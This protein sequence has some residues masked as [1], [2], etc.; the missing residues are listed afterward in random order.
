MSAG[1]ASPV[2]DFAHSIVRDYLRELG[3]E[4]TL[5]AFT[6]EAKALKVQPPTTDSWYAVSQR[7]DLPA[8]IRANN[9]PHGRHHLAMLEVLLEHLLTETGRVR[10]ATQPPTLTV[11]RRRRGAADDKAQGGGGGGGGRR[12]REPQDEGGQLVA[13]QQMGRSSGAAM[14][15]PGYGLGGGGGA[16]GAGSGDELPSGGPSEAQ[17]REAAAAAAAARAAKKKKADDLAA[18]AAAGGGGGKAES[19]KKEKA[20]KADFGLDEDAAWRPSKESW[21]PMDTRMRMMRE[22]ISANKNR[23]A[24]EAREE[25]R[26]KQWSAEGANTALELE[27][28]R[29]K[30]SCK[31]QQK[32][33]LCALEFLRVNLPMVVSFKAVIDLRASW[34]CVGEQGSGVDGE[35]FANL[36]RPPRCYDTTSI[37][38]FCAQFFDGPNAQQAYRPVEEEPDSRPGMGLLAGA[39]DAIDL[40]NPVSDIDH[41][42][43]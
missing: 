23:V 33:G 40:F 41:G 7:L 20:E 3:F 9:G 4:K 19:K 34:G 8:I 29:E 15:P 43:K 17:L 32:C 2:E 31:R 16:G 35:S 13:S 27:R 18:K 39:S 11:T 10:A 42:N 30:Y 37:C 28:T 24:V 22:E 38:V 5:D 21:I 14:G 36:S 12:Q 26:L 1:D 25:T 6:S